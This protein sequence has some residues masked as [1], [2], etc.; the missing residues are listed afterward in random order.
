MRMVSDIRLLL[1]RFE[2][3]SCTRMQ[4]VNWASL[5]EGGGA[6]VSVEMGKY[7]CCADPSC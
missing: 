3:R 7:V 1:A 2:L 6:S 4:S 5:N